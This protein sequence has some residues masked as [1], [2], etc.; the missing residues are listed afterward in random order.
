MNDS[1]VRFSIGETGH[2]RS[3]TQRREGCEG[4]VKESKPSL[5]GGHPFVSLVR[6][7]C[8]FPWPVW[9][10]ERTPTTFHRERNRTGSRIGGASANV[11]FRQVIL[12]LPAAIDDA[13]L[14]EILQ[15]SFFIHAIELM[16]N[17]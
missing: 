6:V 8:N 16:E 7:Y 10:Y 5:H 14:I 4:Y 13:T 12:H 2:Q 11:P 17:D 9:A 3:S 15:I 1:N